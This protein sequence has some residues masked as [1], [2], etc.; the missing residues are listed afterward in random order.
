MQTSG[1]VQDDFFGQVELKR[2]PSLQGRAFAI[3]QHHDII[4]V[5][6]LGRAAG[7]KKHMSP[8]EARALL[9]PVNGLLVSM[10]EHCFR[11]AHHAA[12]CRHVLLC[13]CMCT[14]K[15]CALQ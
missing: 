8:P 7:V 6:Y 2:D 9:K 15:R 5:S 14:A 12:R 1:A 10:S 13:R 11:S 3:Q 4:A